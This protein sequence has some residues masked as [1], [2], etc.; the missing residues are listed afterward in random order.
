MSDECVCVWSGNDESIRK[1]NQSHSSTGFGERQINVKFPYP[2]RRWDA[3]DF[4]ERKNVYH[5]YMK[6]N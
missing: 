2:V 1:G 4:L 5:R 3:R 6:V